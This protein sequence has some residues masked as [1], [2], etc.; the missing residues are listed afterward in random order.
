VTEGTG[1]LRK[2][3]NGQIVIP[4][5]YRQMEQDEEDEEDGENPDDEHVNGEEE[6]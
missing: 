6:G 2:V 1:L 5:Q 3:E 4:E